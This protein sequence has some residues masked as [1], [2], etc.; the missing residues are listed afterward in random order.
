MALYAVGGHGHIFACIGGAAGDVHWLW[1]RPSDRTNK[2]ALKN[3]FRKQD[4]S[5]LSSIIAESVIYSPPD[6]A[7]LM[8]LRLKFYEIYVVFTLYLWFVEY[9][10]WP[11]SLF[12][13]ECTLAQSPSN[14][15]SSSRLDQGAK[16]QQLWASVWHLNCGVL[17]VNESWLVG[18]ILE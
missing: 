6:V 2:S 11:L 5:I 8:I 4:C 3:S 17:Y 7:D 12:Q 13:F 1:L 9:F 18:R 15:H 10:L 16:S 14:V